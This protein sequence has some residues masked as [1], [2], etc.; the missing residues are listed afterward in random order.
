M[1]TLVIFQHEGQLYE[2]EI[3]EDISI[4]AILNRTGI[5]IGSSK[6]TI[7]LSQNI[8]D[9]PIH[10]SFMD[11]FMNVYDMNLLLTHQDVFDS[12]AMERLTGCS[13][14]DSIA[15]LFQV[16]YPQYKQHIHGFFYIECVGY[17]EEY[18]EVRENNSVIIT[19]A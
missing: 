4:I 14:N 8:Q 1:T 10:R 16:F 2:A 19:T 18:K 5:V 7:I 9:Y 15:T 11:A 6:E 17:K 12:I 13:R 3:P